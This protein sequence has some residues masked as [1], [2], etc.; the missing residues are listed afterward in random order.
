MSDLDE[1]AGAVV[2][3][4]GRTAV[5]LRDGLRKRGRVSLTTADVV[6]VLEANPARFAPDG[7][8]PPTWWPSSSRPRPGPAAAEVAPVVAGR[9]GGPPLHAWQD[10]A[11]R[12]WRSRG[13]RGV[14]E[15]VTGTGKSMVG[16][17]A[18]AA[19]LAVGGQVCVLVPTRQLLDQWRAVLAATL[20]VHTSIGLLGAGHRD[21]LDHHDVLVA[22]VDSARLAD[23]VPRR[24]GG[25][26]VADECHR[27]GSDGNRVVLGVGF[28]RRL[29]LSATYAR[30]DDG[31]LAWLDPYFGGTCYRLGYRRAVADGITARFRVALLG[32]TFAPDERATYD[33][34]TRSMSTARARL[35][36][37][38]GLVAEP[39]GAFFAAAARLARSG[40]DG[41][42]AVA[43]RQYLRAMQER[44]ALLAETPVK[45]AALASL[46]PALRAADRSIVFTQSIA[47]AERAAATLDVFGLAAAA[48]HSGQDAATRR[49]VLDRF[50]TGALAVV[51]APQVLDEGVDVP[52]A[53]LAVIL[54]ASRSRR[55]MVQRM[56]RVLRRKADGRLA[57]FCIVAVEGTVE[58]PATGAHEG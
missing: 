10:E 48:V 32:V 9:W 6:R 11:L 2:D 26:L 30:A 57:R 39:V 29:G 3:T 19:E 31:H 18:T 44:R 37:R 54:A 41:P 34:L 49:A 20:P 1:V 56:G 45:A 40:G 28:A 12:A 53:D 5:E 51:A 33:D 17:A 27:Y 24:P 8:V 38:E 22:V 21:R 55:Q 36:G 4:P 15:A 46:T 43:A 50:A 7:A 13:G 25:L 16:A 35:L 52:A 58:D 42:G 47:A 23:L 14:V